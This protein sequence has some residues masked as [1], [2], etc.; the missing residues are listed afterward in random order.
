M[1][2]GKK[3]TY[4]YM[5]PKIAEKRKRARKLAKVRK[6]G[7]EE[8]VVINNYDANK[9]QFA[10]SRNTSPTLQKKR[11]I[12]PGENKVAINSRADDRIQQ[13]AI[14]KTR[15][16]VKK[17]DDTAGA[18]DVPKKTKKKPKRRTKKATGGTS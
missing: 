14:T 8:P 15:P 13:K 2:V 16:K 10:S 18:I 11:L 4:D 1:P 5:S 12:S 17:P 6:E 7:G 3:K 9:P